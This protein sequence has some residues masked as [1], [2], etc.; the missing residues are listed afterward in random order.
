MTNNDLIIIPKPDYISWEEIT[1]LLNRG[2]KERENEGLIYKAA[3]QSVS[4][5]IERGSSNS[6][7]VLVA[8]LKDNLIGTITYRVMQN[9]ENINWYYDSIYIHFGQLAVDPSIKKKGVGSKLLEKIETIGLEN[10]VDSLIANTSV[11]AKWLLKWYYRTGF[12]KVDFISHPSTNYYSIVFR[13]PLHGKSYPVFYRLFKFYFSKFKCLILR[14]QT[15]GL[16]RPF[17]ILK[18][19]YIK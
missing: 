13:K 18:N 7:V 9:N 15:G 16:R 5:T 1:I 17:K 2:Y 4:E 10:S 8:L 19:S 14:K 3:N 12:K 6:G 11:K